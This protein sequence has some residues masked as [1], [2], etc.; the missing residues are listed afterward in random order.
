MICAV[1]FAQYLKESRVTFVVIFPR[2]A[3]DPDPLPEKVWTPMILR[4]SVG[5]SALLLLGSLMAE[6]RNEGVGNPLAA[7]ARVTQIMF[8]GCVIDNA[9]VSW[10]GIVNGTRLHLKYDGPWG[11]GEVKGKL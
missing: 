2:A 5:L 4:M 6:I 8:A 7:R 1:K 3:R 10:L 11:G 9:F